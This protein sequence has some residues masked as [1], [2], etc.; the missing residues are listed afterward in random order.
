M[1]CLNQR[2]ADHRDEPGLTMFGSIATKFRAFMEELAPSPETLDRREAA[3]VQK[4]CAGLLME[5]ARI[6][7]EEVERKREAAVQAMRELFNIAD[8]EL[9]PMIANA[10]RREN[11]LTSYYRPVKLLNRRFAPA[12]KTQFIEQLWRVAMADGRID[13]YED[14]LVRKL[15]DLLYVAHTDFI[16][17]KRRVQSG[18]VP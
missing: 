2:T 1:N 4:A 7:S 12:R 17:A 11:R 15:S 10:G 9:L 3:A 14:Q 8:P 18:S 13:M 6:E 5:V 16:L